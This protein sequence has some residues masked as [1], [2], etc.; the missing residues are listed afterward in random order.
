MKL[1]TF[2]AQMMKQADGNQI[3]ILLGQPGLGDLV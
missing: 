1:I 2:I 3:R